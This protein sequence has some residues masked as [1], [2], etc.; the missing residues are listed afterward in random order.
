MKGRERD[1]S[2]ICKPERTGV[3]TGFA[4]TLANQI[5]LT[6]ILLIPVFVWHALKYT[7]GLEKGAPDERLW[8][9]AVVTFAL[10]ALSDA[11][12]GW[13]ARRF[14]QRTRLGGILDPL[15]DKLLML[16]V[17]GVV[18]FSAWPV[19][20]PIYFVVIVFAR[21]IFTTIGAFVIKHKA[22]KVQ[23]DPHWSGKVSTFLG[24]ATLGCALLF[25]KSVVPWAAACAALFAFSSGMLYIAEA[26]RQINAADHDNTAK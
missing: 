12:D 11:L 20:F 17:V 16:A 13:V 5:T 14:N 10:A 1:V 22:G 8:F 15:A 4:V 25:M 18:T 26:V 2:K 9:W 21:E 6:R 3:W 23:I 19:K 24:L 7:Q